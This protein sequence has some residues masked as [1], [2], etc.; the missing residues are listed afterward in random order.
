[1]EGTAI[2]TQHCLTFVLL[3]HMS[4]IENFGAAMATQK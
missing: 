3:S 4:A 1:M 2:K